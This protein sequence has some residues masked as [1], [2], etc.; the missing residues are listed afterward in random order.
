MK[1]LQ[2]LPGIENAFR[3]ISKHEQIIYN[4]LLIELTRAVKKL[5][6]SWN[7]KKGNWTEKGNW[8]DNKRT[9]EYNRVGRFA[10]AY[11]NIIKFEIDHF[12]EEHKISYQ[13]ENWDLNLWD[14]LVSYPYGQYQHFF[15]RELFWIWDDYALK[16][17]SI[18]GMIAKGYININ[19]IDYKK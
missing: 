19:Q 14:A 17:E 7:I 18:S 11:K 5:S 15:S 4:D 9:A 2:G 6:K 16:F 13:I 3:T 8:T 1:Q 12:S 10:E